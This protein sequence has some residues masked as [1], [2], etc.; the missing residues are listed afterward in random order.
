M[1]TKACFQKRYAYDPDDKGYVAVTMKRA[2]GSTFKAYK[3]WEGEEGAFEQ[4]EEDITTVVMGTNLLNG[5]TI[6]V[7]DQ[8]EDMFKRR[9]AL[10]S[11]MSQ[12]LTMLLALTL[13]TL[14]S[15]YIIA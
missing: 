15:R 14:H 1:L 6:Y 2:N 13:I 7:K 10:Q 11:G 9:C 3:F 12:N 4:L 5:T 8:Q